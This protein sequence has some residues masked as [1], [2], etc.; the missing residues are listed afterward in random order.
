MSEPVHVDRD[1]FLIGIIGKIVDR[2]CLYVF[3]FGVVWLVKDG[4]VQVVDK[5]PEQIDALTALVREFIG[6]FTSKNVH[7]WGGWP[8]AGIFFVAWKMERHGKKRAIE[9]LGQCREALEAGDIGGR[10]SSGLSPTG[11]TPKE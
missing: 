5:S 6:L 1:I 11:D 3:L 9:K 10:S 4:I 8:V 7:L 2:V